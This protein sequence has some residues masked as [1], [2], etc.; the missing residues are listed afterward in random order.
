MKRSF[1]YI[2]AFLILLSSIGA[3][4]YYYLDYSQWVEKNSTNTTSS[5][6]EK[7]SS[8]TKTWPKVYEH[9]TP[10][11]VS[12]NDYFKWEFIANDI[13]WVYSRRDAIVKDILVD[14]WDSVRK[15]DVLALLLEPWVE[16]QAATTLK[17]RS[18]RV[19]SQWKI[20]S[21]TKKVL[22]AKIE[23]F[24]GKI[25]E[26]EV[27]LN[28]M[29]KNYNQ[30]IAL[31]ENAYET[32]KQSLQLALEKERTVLS[33]LTTRL[34]NTKVV[35]N[36]DVDTLT[37]QIDN[38]KNTQTQKKETL[39]T[40]LENLQNKHAEE[41]SDL[42]TN[43]VQRK[44]LFQL[45]MD[46][47]YT[48]VIPLIYIW[49]ESSIDYDSISKGDL[50]DYFSAKDSVNLSTL[51]EKVR[52]YQAAK[53]SFDIDT[54]YNL[55][56]EVIDY[57][58]IGLES[59][60]FSLGDT[61]E[62]TVTSYIWKAQTYKSILVSQKELYS[63][64]QSDVTVLKAGQKKEKES[65]ES[66]IEQIDADTLAQIV[67]LQKQTETQQIQWTVNTD[68]IQKQ[69][70]EQ[71]SKISLLESDIALYKD[72]NS[73]ALI[74][75]EKSLKTWA[76]QAEIATLR[77]SKKL[78]IANEN[79]KITRAWND[80]LEAKADLDKEYVES[81]D[82]RIISPFTGIV[83]KRDLEVWQ[84][85]TQSKEAFRLIWVATDLAKWAKKEVKFYVPEY[86]LSEI[87]IGK[88]IN[89]STTDDSGKLYTAK[90]W[91]ISPEIDSE[92]LTVTVQAK[93]QGNL[94]LP[95]KSTLRVWLET[96]E[97]TFKVPASAI[98]NKWE[99]KIVYYKKENGKLWVKDITIIS[100]DWEFALVAWEFDETL[101]VVTTAIFVK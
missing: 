71:V 75:S 40:E 6:L 5:G 62:T 70:E 86:L 100:D 23:E 74:R 32:K 30:K 18:T 21:E 97:N 7:I 98:Y 19:D 91:R 41:L 99:R 53:D 76:L 101:K 65:I 84:K 51:L 35:E 9:M 82:Y 83:S 68:D 26:K 8:E 12:K 11:R 90:V 87:T 1:L 88:E 13:A 61:E 54:Q 85:V 77:K 27:V 3:W 36:D 16:G 44:E 14:V 57:T 45:K 29:I 15:W 39:Q 92:T 48:Q 63:D 58:L 24:D 94:S 56:E 17:S 95:H 60:L 38:L 25:S 73:V 2:A 81:K 42:E 80:L 50:N 93:V 28:E 69:I 59:T 78:L 22:S 4:A 10:E 89:F 55:L 37:V 34:K 52:E 49:E 33:T 31:S 67:N 20:L 72:E 47:L 43:I 96:K 46:E 79:M 66:A 64:T